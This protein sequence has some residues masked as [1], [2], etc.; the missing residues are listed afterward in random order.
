M[1]FGK[2]RGEPLWRLPKMYLQ[3]LAREAELNESLKS[4]VEHELGLRVE[5]EARNLLPYGRRGGSAIDGRT[6]RHRWVWTAYHEFPFGTDTDNLTPLRIV[7][8][9]F[10]AIAFYAPEVS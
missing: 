8:T 4:A 3:W 2:Y 5:C 9:N 7:T 1:P 10:L 6:T